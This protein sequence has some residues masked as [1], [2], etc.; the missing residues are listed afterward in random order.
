MVVPNHSPI[1]AVAIALNTYRAER[2]NKGF[3][4]G[5]AKPQLPI[6]RPLISQLSQV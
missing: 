5:F 2:G 6:T 4:W 1:F 3:D